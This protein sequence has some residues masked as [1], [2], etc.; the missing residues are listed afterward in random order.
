MEHPLET[1]LSL[2]SSGIQ[3]QS[4]T[5][6]R[7]YRNSVT[8]QL[9]RSRRKLKIQVRPHK[10]SK[11]SWKPKE[12]TSEEV[13]NDPGFGDVLV[14]QAEKS[15]AHAMESK[16]VIETNTGALSSKRK[17][18]IS[19][20]SKA[21]KYT[22]QISDALDSGDVSFSSAN[23]KLELYA[24][25]SLIEGA[26]RFEQ[27]NWEKTVKAY[28]I[29]RVILDMF[30]QSEE[31]MK[32]IITTLVDPAL[33]YAAYRSKRSRSADIPTLAKEIVASE[34]MTSEPVVQ[35]VK[36]VDPSVLNFSSSNMDP[37]AQ[38]G[39]INW[40]GHSAKVSDPDLASCIIIAKEK[41]ASFDTKNV[42][43]FDGVLQGWQEALDMIRENIE[44]IE[45]SPERASTHD[46]TSQE[47]YIIL[48]YIS[49]NLLFRRIERDLLLIK[50]LET[51][52][53]KTVRR[54]LEQAR[55]VIRIYDTILQSTFQLVNL[56]GV[57]Q[58][59]SLSSS[60]ETVDSYY[61]IQRTLWVAKAYSIN[62]DKL[63]ALA[64]Y[65]YSQK[66]HLKGISSISV[67]FPGNVVSQ[68]DVD[69]VVKGLESELVRAHGLAV[70]AKQQQ[71]QV[72][73]S[74]DG[75]SVVDSLDEYPKGTP[76]QI[77]NNL[78]DFHP[79]LKPAPVKPVYFD[80]AFNFIDYS[81]ED[82]E[83]VLQQDAADP[84]V[85]SDNS[86]KKGGFFGSLLGRR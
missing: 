66:E 51:R 24:Y 16:A 3:L 78:V 84:S 49:Y 44:E 42:T 17:H 52:P 67:D 19:K 6:Y 47:Q 57:N 13:S 60:L 50:G 32:D 31:L 85:E 46:N 15:W 72:T 69:K 74:K 61:K 81:E 11:A 64:L 14:F 75:D 26:L 76:E 5:D 37:S 53:A 18:V 10:G 68:Q 27:H 43:S 82:K 34:K 7:S 83:I 38:L 8:K 39:E 80:I 59:D 41:E 28:S 20:L 77:L 62:G 71:S 1:I 40:R 25:H 73:D 70:L 56:P 55:D 35:L 65:S 36:Q 12:V 86:K 23:S 22:K 48:T 79:K 2:R 29:A 9:A 45:S 30:Q 54:K 21:F 33:S 58:D 4:A 63:T